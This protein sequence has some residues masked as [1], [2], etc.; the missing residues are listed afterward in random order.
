MLDK[1][2]CMKKFRVII[3]HC[4]IFNVIVDRLQNIPFTVTVVKPLQ[5]MFEP[6]HLKEMGEQLY[7]TT[8][9]F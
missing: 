1:F 9:T 2:I 7:S 4:L 5:Q 8:N 6:Q 3:S